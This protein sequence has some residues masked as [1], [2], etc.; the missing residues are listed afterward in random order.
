MA[1]RSRFGGWIFGRD[2]AEGATGADDDGDEEDLDAGVVAGQEA[3]QEV[4]AEEHDASAA[5]MQLEMILEGVME[6]AQGGEDGHGPAPHEHPEIG[7]LLPVPD[8]DQ[9]PDREASFE[10]NIHFFDPHD[11]QEGGNWGFE[12]EDLVVEEEEEFPVFTMEQILQRIKEDAEGAV[13]LFLE[14][15][16]KCHRQKQQ[17][18]TEIL[19]RKRLELQISEQQATMESLSEEITSRRNQFAADIKAANLR[20]RVE[21]ERLKAD[22]NELLRAQVEAAQGA[23]TSVPAV[24]TDTI[25]SGRRR[26]ERYS[27]LHPISGGKVALSSERKLLEDLSSRSAR[28][29]DRN[30]EDKDLKDTASQLMK[31][32]ME[33]D[34]DGGNSLHLELPTKYWK[35]DEKSRVISHVIKKMSVKYTSKK[36][37]PFSNIIG[38]L[39]ELFADPEVKLPILAKAFRENGLQAV[40]GVYSEVYKT[41]LGQPGISEERK[42]VLRQLRLDDSDVIFAA[43][44]AAFAHLH[45]GLNT[46][47]SGTLR[48]ESQVSDLLASKGFMALALARRYLFTQRVS[49]MPERL[50][51][52]VNL[53]AVFKDLFNGNIATYRMWIQRMIAEFEDDF[54]AIDADVIEQALVLNEVMHPSD[55]AL[56]EFLKKIKINDRYTKQM[57]NYAEMRASYDLF[58]SEVAIFVKENYPNKFYTEPRSSQ[59]ITI[60]VEAHLGKKLPTETSHHANISKTTAVHFRVGDTTPMCKSCNRHHPTGEGCLTLANWNRVLESYGPIARDFEAVRKELEKLIKMISSGKSSTLTEHPAFN[61]AAEKMLKFLRAMQQSFVKEQNNFKKRQPKAQGGRGGFKNV[62]LLAKTT[63]SPDK[64]DAAK[65]RIAVKAISQIIADA[66]LPPTSCIYWLTEGAIPQGAKHCKRGAACRFI[67]DPKHEKK[68]KS[69]QAHVARI[70]NCAMDVLPAGKPDPQAA[71][72]VA[73]PK[74]SPKKKAAGTQ[75][76]QFASTPQSNVN[77]LFFDNLLFKATTSG[78]ELTAMENTNMGV[79]SSIFFHTESVNSGGKGSG[80]LEFEECQNDSKSVEYKEKDADDNG[81]PL[82]R[83]VD[84]NRILLRRHIPYIP[85]INV[86]DNGILLRRNIPYIPYIGDT[87]PDQAG[88]NIQVFVK[89]LEGKTNA[90]SINDDSTLR[91]LKAASDNAMKYAG[92]VPEGVVWM[93]CGTAHLNLDFKIKDYEIVSGQTIYMI[94]RLRAGSLPWYKQA[95]YNLKAHSEQIVSLVGKSKYRV[96][97]EMV[98][99]FEND[100][101][102]DERIYV[103]GDERL[104]MLEM[105]VGIFR[106]Q[107]EIDTKKDGVDEL[108][109]FRAGHAFTAEEAEHRIS[110]LSSEMSIR[111]DRMEAGDA[112]MR[113][114]S[115]VEKLK[116]EIMKHID[117]DDT[118]NSEEDTQ[119][120]YSLTAEVCRNLIQRSFVDT[121]VELTNHGV[122]TTHMEAEWLVLTIATLQLKRGAHRDFKSLTEYHSLNGLLDSYMNDEE[123]NEMAMTLGKNEISFNAYI[124]L[125]LYARQIIDAY[126]LLRLSIRVRVLKKKQAEFYKE[127]FI[128]VLKDCEFLNVRYETQDIIRTNGMRSGRILQMCQE[129]AD[130]TGVFVDD[131]SPLIGLCSGVHAQALAINA[132]ESLQAIWDKRYASLFGE[133]YALF[134]GY[135]E[136]LLNAKVCEELLGTQVTSFIEPDALEAASYVYDQF[137][138]SR[139]YSI[140]QQNNFETQKAGS[141]L[142][143]ENDP[144]YLIRGYDVRRLKAYLGV[145]SEKFRIRTS[146]KPDDGYK[147]Y[148]EVVEYKTM[149]CYLDRLIH[150]QLVFDYRG[151]YAVPHLRNSIEFLAMPSTKRNGDI[152]DDKRCKAMLRPPYCRCESFRGNTRG[153][154]AD[155]DDG[156]L[157]GYMSQIQLR[158]LTIQFERI[159]SAQLAF[160][161]ENYTSKSRCRLKF[162]DV[163]DMFF[164]AKT[165][166]NA[167]RDV[168]EANQ[169]ITLRRIEGMESKHERESVMT[170]AKAVLGQNELTL[171][172]TNIPF[173]TQGHQQG[174]VDGIPYRGDLEGGYIQAFDKA[175]ES[176][177]YSIDEIQTVSPMLMVTQ[178]KDIIYAKKRANDEFV[179]AM[180]NFAVEAIEAI[181][182]LAVSS[183]GEAEKVGSKLMSAALRVK[184]AHFIM[185]EVNI[186]SSFLPRIKRVLGVVDPQMQVYQSRVDLINE[187]L[188]TIQ[189]EEQRAIILFATQVCYGKATAKDVF[190][191]LG[192]WKCPRPNCRCRN[193]EDPVERHRLQ[194]QYMHSVSPDRQ[195]QLLDPRDVFELKRWS[196]GNEMYIREHYLTRI[197][198]KASKYRCQ[199]RYRCQELNGSRPRKPSSERHL[200]FVSLGFDTG[201]SSPIL[202]FYSQETYQQIN[203]IR[204]ILKP[205]IQDVDRKIHCK[206]VHMVRDEIVSMPPPMG[207]QILHE[208]SNR[209]IGMLRQKTPISPFPA[210][211]YEAYVGDDGNDYNPEPIARLSA[212]SGNMRV[213]TV[214][215]W[216]HSIIAAAEHGFSAPRYMIGER[217]FATKD[218]SAA[219]GWDIMDYK[220]LETNFRFEMVRND[221][222]I[223]IYEMLDVNGKQGF[224][225]KSSAGSSLKTLR[226][227]VHMLYRIAWRTKVNYRY[228]TGVWSPFGKPTRYEGME[229]QQDATRQAR[230]SIQPQMAA[231]GAECS[232]ESLTRRHLDMLSKVFEI[233]R[234]YRKSLNTSLSEQQR[235]IL[236]DACAAWKATT[237]EGRIRKNIDKMAMKRLKG[238][239]FQKASM[240]LAESSSASASSNPQAPIRG[241]KTPKSCKPEE[242]KG[243]RRMDDDD[244]PA[245]AEG[246]TRTQGT[247]TSDNIDTADGLAGK[248][249]GAQGEQSSTQNKRFRK[250]VFQVHVLNSGEIHMTVLSMDPHAS[251]T[252]MELERPA[253]QIQTHAKKSP[254]S[255]SWVSKKD[256][257]DPLRNRT[258]RIRLSWRKR[259]EGGGSED[260]LRLSTHWSR[261][262]KRRKKRVAARR[263]YWQYWSQNCFWAMLDMPDDWSEWGSIWNYQPQPSEDDGASYGHTPLYKV[264]RRWEMGNIEHNATS[265]HDAS[266][267]DPHED[268]ESIFGSAWEPWANDAAIHMGSLPSLQ[269]IDSAWSAWAN[270]AMIQLNPL[271]PSPEENQH[272]DPVQATVSDHESESETVR[273]HSDSE[274]SIPG[275]IGSD[276]SSSDD[277]E[278]PPNVPTPSPYIGNTGTGNEISHSDASS[279]DAESGRIPQLARSLSLGG[280][281]TSSDHNEAGVAAVG[282]APSIYI[283]HSNATY[284]TLPDTRLRYKSTGNWSIIVRQLTQAQLILPEQRHEYTHPLSTV[285]LTDA[286]TLSNYSED[287]NR[288]YPAV[289]QSDNGDGRAFVSRFL[290]CYKATPSQGRILHLVDSGS[291]CFLSPITEHFLIPARTAMRINGVGQGLAERVS[292]LAI[293]TVT[294]H[295]SYHLI[296]YP[297]VYGLTNGGLT[298]PI[299]PTGKL[300][301]QGYKF[302]LEAEHGHLKTPQEDIVPLLF[303]ATTG[304][305]WLVERLYARTTVEWKMKYFD[306]WEKHP[307]RSTVQLVGTPNVPTVDMIEIPPVKP[308]TQYEVDRSLVEGANWGE[309]SNPAMTRAAAKAG[310]INKQLQQKESVTMNERNQVL[311]TKCLRKNCKFPRR[312]IGNQILPFCSKSC[313]KEYV[314]DR[315]GYENADLDTKCQREDCAYPR[316]VKDGV[317][318]PYC[319]KRCQESVEGIVGKINR[320]KGIYEAEKLVSKRDFDGITKW[321]VR[322][323][324]FAPKHDTWEPKENISQELIREF[325]EY[326]AEREAGVD[327][328]DSINRNN[329]SEET[330]E[331]IEIEEDSDAISN[332][333]SFDVSDEKYIRDQK[334]AALKKGQK[335]LKLKFPAARLLDTGEAKEVQQLKR[336]VHDLMGHLGNDSILKAIDHVDGLEVIKA[337]E[338]IR[339]HSGKL[340]CD[341]CSENRERMPAVPKGKTARLHS[342][343]NI[344][345]IYVD[346]SGKVEEKSIYHGYHYYVAAV[347]DYGFAFVEGITFRSQALLAL[348]RI[349]ADAEGKI[350]V[351]QVDGEGNLNSKIAEDYFAGRNIK[352]ITTEAYAHFRN[353]KIEIRHKLWKG[354][355]RAM[356]S[357]AGVH[358]GWWHHAVRHAVLITN[359]MLLTT[360]VEGEGDLKSMTVWERHFG[361]RPNVSDYLI[362]PFGCLCYLVLSKEQRQQRGLS[363]HWGVRSIQGLY[364]G[365]RVN[366]KT[367]VYTHLITDGRS[368]FGS[369]N[370]VKPVVDAFPMRWTLTKELPIIPRS[371]EH[372]HEE[373]NL[374]ASVRAWKQANEEKADDTRLRRDFLYE[375]SMGMKT[376]YKGEDRKKGLNKKSPF[377]VVS[378]DGGGSPDNADVFAPCIEKSVEINLENPTDYAIN[379]SPTD[380][381]FTEPYEGAKYQLVIPIDFSDGERVPKETTHPHRRF[382]GRKVRKIFPIP[383]GGASR[384]KAEVVEG[385]VKSYQEQ[386]QLFKI[387]YD[388]GDREEVDFTELMEILI[389]DPK[390]GDSDSDRGKTRREREERAK[391]EALMIS[392]L[393]EVMFNRPSLSSAR[394]DGSDNED[395][396]RKMMGLCHLLEEAFVSKEG[397]SLDTTREP[398]YDDEPRNQKELDAHPEKDK[399]LEAAAKEMQALIDMDIGVQLTEKQAND[400]IKSGVKILRSKM[401]YKRK[402]GISEADGKEY[403][404]KWKG[405]L[406]IVGT[407]ETE[408]V[409]TVYNTF[410]PTVGFTAIRTLISLLCN[411]KYHVGSYDLSS[412]FVATELEDRAVYVKLPSDAGASG[413]KI[414]RLTKNVY[415]MKNSG[416]AFVQKLGREIL[417]F[418][419]IFI[420]KSGREGKAQFQRLPSDQCIFRYRDSLGREMILL[421]YVDDIVCATTDPDLRDRFFKHLNKTWKITDEGTLNRFLGVHFERSKDGWKWKATMATYIDRIVERFGL[422]ESRRVDTPME[423]GFVLTEEDFQEEPTAEMIHEMRSLIG[424]IGY[425]ATAIRFDVSY[426]VS[427]LS[428]HLVKPCRKVID[429]AKRVI[430]YLDSTKDF[431]IEWWASE[432]DVN[433]GMSN[434]LFGATDAS[435]AM[436]PISRKSHGGYINFINHGAVSWKSGL[437]PIVTLS[438][439]EAEYVA[440]CAAVCE[441]KYIRSLMRD[442]GY[443]QDDASLIWEDNKAA[444]LIAE[445]E[446]SSAG[447]SKHI[448]VKF[449][450]V[451]QAIAE[452]VVRIR[453]ISTNLNFA[454]L[455]TKPLVKDIFKRLVKLCVEDKHEHFRSI[456]VSSAEEEVR[457]SIDK[458]QCD[459]G[460][461]WKT[462]DLT[463]SMLE[464]LWS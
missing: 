211:L 117:Y 208:L 17:L 56:K 230:W 269:A 35:P 411:P 172:K 212:F 192:T 397:P 49:D 224:S 369:P 393:E 358:I 457:V 360:S 206:I 149:R 330:G 189:H 135:D 46:D 435:Y 87:M 301:L 291:T 309:Q 144:L 443:E 112:M 115:A 412:A 10:D 20:T 167:E 341:S 69:Q 252:N 90:I 98:L 268:S 174:V 315:D 244:D 305:H 423:A 66:K 29:P 417:A 73:G 16:R 455:F 416:K 84:D 122:I 204:Q 127:E 298:F 432:R 374:V 146:V 441:V 101:H 226:N 13:Y 293:S 52:L 173:Y 196:H 266:S 285:S 5:A 451:A 71:P 145:P 354:M 381:V 425:C 415:G 231:V 406:A 197:M 143:D 316:I 102:G 59:E 295:G 454:D 399:I 199:E 195:L 164:H 191:I 384:M 333:E 85:Y 422:K 332:A 290:S 65:A 300:E 158:H 51:I 410:S 7:E 48:H 347:T 310:P 109:K 194:Q 185:D 253:V 119:A 99:Q 279:S 462:V 452:G 113:K 261:F 179:T 272:I 355:A 257:N 36:L 152:L 329:P 243:K 219:P 464:S 89:S 402:Y 116:C 302:A 169:W 181:S 446:C 275:L 38:D 137:R 335:P 366:P 434:R 322:W 388:D 228:D 289:L 255:F 41:A 277:D 311:G 353:G 320:K 392:W 188:I 273:Q 2:A 130:H 4:D 386:R 339:T 88:K 175:L 385:T 8:A 198:N 245:G 57:Q 190:Q 445:N 456:E 75:Q 31:L 379:P 28:A 183:K 171:R 389:M 80:L 401:V 201:G 256:S 163:C 265:V 306:Q 238:Q 426:A 287:G 47:L 418:E 178:T 94:G 161:Q 450:F 390:F 184:Q 449:K 74:P 342:K 68:L 160:V 176:I 225:I 104:R 148:K 427:I 398:I 453:Y 368:I 296:K 349:I 394:S 239:D 24:D 286:A 375:T 251:L 223:S 297:A 439:C 312:M 260:F 114:I 165:K 337:L 428:R 313:G 207:I 407:G 346:L 170:C 307:A 458:D 216:L 372:V 343:G 328:D 461:E 340:H 70:L 363:S 200:S 177:A 154:W 351:V 414:V 12:E 235:R 271:L 53:G 210:G 254:L 248:S 60:A 18:Q 79:L 270:E 37:P 227:G 350:R 63:P 22:L 125:K 444:I 274:D 262:L 460:D 281:S 362:A 359:I 55:N 242:Q 222:V 72:K 282:S 391:N 246:D 187:E 365:C 162:F 67:H 25:S 378:E 19:T 202:S 45:A 221:D 82:R 203:I 121:I 131:G 387:S 240:M 14:F 459:M 150:R 357:R 331:Q 142:N 214:L 440:L 258:H 382:V 126:P 100:L 1:D 463:E 318:L 424:S 299:M 9:E 292:P 373:T 138:G 141:K 247:G 139:F 395:E 380:V 338:A 250:Q 303:D 155:G 259:R 284:H 27:G 132:S 83:N 233:R 334:I 40:I 3:Q 448:D 409:D 442:L 92:P 400:V 91:E 64:T 433:D 280:D 76:V 430:K 186:E 6:Q 217:H 61:S 23:A 166:V 361:V 21:T 314:A 447:R 15:Q 11:Q 39:M 50:K 408:G 345:K 317:L 118:M 54:G 78:S 44:K 129:L 403:F 352:L 370:A 283:G 193:L 105:Q 134:H 205:W 157:S 124:G 371:D 147:S 111:L 220:G 96:D 128:E 153:A 278:D 336:E 241:S 376:K 107:E 377:R 364:L 93:R 308:D 288:V 62:A 367:G 276:S 237:L 213:G 180:L 438:S 229:V 26:T 396:R 236:T 34:D 413:N 324:N 437:Q 234:K 136:L 97:R 215:K 327:P 156:L 33:L 294:S 419:E 43:V 323:R 30:K 133:L 95:D 420:D 264:W 77:N 429:A 321:K 58:V 405:R 421:H 123:F 326:E 263:G 319:S 325:E 182:L 348:A 108:V 159:V 140:I 356:M 404:L 168:M 209:W 249:E 232:T 436:D 304:F 383:T 120:L 110:D 103:R 32:A 344:Q 431:S 267:H 81:I 218:S 151:D 86:D 106:S 42:R